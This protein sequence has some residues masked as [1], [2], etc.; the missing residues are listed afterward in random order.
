VVP[1]REAA[2]GHACYFL[3]FESSVFS[4]Q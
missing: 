3:S 1:A 4:L 2:F